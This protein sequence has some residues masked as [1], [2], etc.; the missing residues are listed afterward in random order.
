M[1]GKLRDTDSGS[2]SRPV[3][4]SS[5]R[6]GMSST[7]GVLAAGDWAWAWAVAASSKANP[8]TPANVWIR[9]MTP[10]PS[11]PWLTMAQLGLRGNYTVSE[12]PAMVGQK[13]AEERVPC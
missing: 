11:R 5:G 6:S 3:P 12:K 7:V 9:I 1:T 4:A 8:A 2:N 10:L 13:R